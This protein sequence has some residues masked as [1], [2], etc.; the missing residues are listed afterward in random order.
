MPFNGSGT[1][2]RVHS[3]TADRSNGIRVRSDRMD[4]ED[5]GYAA[6]LSNCIARDGQSTITADI[7]FNN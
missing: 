4:A 1:F 3:W 7:P 6:G 2:Q 5:D